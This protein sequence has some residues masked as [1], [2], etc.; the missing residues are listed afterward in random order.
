[1]LLNTK[2]KLMIVLLLFGLFHFSVTIADLDT[3]ANTG[4]NLSISDTV[5]TTTAFSG[6]V[7]RNNTN[8]RF[9]FSIIFN[10]ADSANFSVVNITIPSNFTFQPSGLDFNRSNGIGSV[11]V[12]GHA[13]A[14][15]G[16]GSWNFGNSTD[17][18]LSNIWW[19]NTDNGT[20]PGHYIFSV[21]LT[22]DKVD[23]IGHSRRQDWN[24]TIYMA[25]ST[26][27]T[28]STLMYTYIDTY[29]PQ[30]MSINISDGLVGGNF[31]RANGTGQASLL[32]QT[33]SYND[34]AYMPIENTTVKV[35]LQ[36]THFDTVDLYYVC[37]SS[38]ATAS[39]TETASTGQYGNVSMTTSDTQS[40]N[41]T[42][43]GV[44]DL[45]CVGT[46]SDGNDKGDT[47]GN[48]TT[49]VIRA[50]DTVGNSI[51]INDTSDNNFLTDNP[52]MFI[53]LDGQPNITALNI[54]DEAGNV[55]D[56]DKNQLGSGRSGVGYLQANSLLTFTI[57]GSGGVIAVAANT[58]NKNAYGYFTFN[59]TA[60]FGTEEN[61]GVAANGYLNLTNITTGAYG[62]T[63][64]TLYNGTIGKGVANDSSDG[65][66][67][68]FIIKINS[69]AV[70]QWPKY[71]R[72]SFVLDGGVPTVAL[73][74]PADKNI[75]PFSS[76]K[77]GCSGTDSVSGMNTCSIKITKP[78][79]STITKTSE[80][81]SDQ[82]FKNTDT[83]EAGTYNVECTTK[84]Q[85]GHT[86]TSTGI[87]TF[88]VFTSTGGGDAS[89][90]G[91]GS[92]ISRS[93]EELVLDADLST[94]DKTTFVGSQGS[95]KV[96]S[97]SGTDAHTITFVKVNENTLTFTIESYKAEV[98]LSVGETKD[99]DMDGDG[100]PNA[101]VTLES[102]TNGVA[103][104]TV[105][106]LKDLEVVAE[107]ESAPSEE[108]PT[109][110]GDIEEKISEKGFGRIMWIVTIIVIVL[111]IV[112]YFYVK[113]RD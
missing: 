60:D 10:S 52:F 28:N 11:G 40:G 76:I 57:E 19:N 31:S 25:D 66:Y 7:Q 54:T 45:D 71:Y 65:N 95:I 39:T 18:T 13:N 103:T 69:T 37:N 93:G 36:D 47:K 79:G 63:N 67:T 29:Y 34:G 55:L 82:E 26:S 84:D 22:A 73:T 98:T 1:M 99:V 27:A 89:S 77:Y 102:I 12:D 78:G 8:V 56:F 16:S 110:S 107:E 87:I 49:F 108:I 17:G 5:A 44:I 92:G 74:E 112:G 101:Q 106:K 24:V 53:G 61:N 68:N 62:A 38:N 109:V 42:Y 83:N 48:A 90:S 94:S 30:I 113:R 4:S 97:L 43:E 72:G 91:G 51:T 105:L 100:T 23:G 15:N 35:D 64:I 20:L 2:I 96:F 6:I 86:T 81:C 85:V 59:T 50:Y 14:T 75:N 33:G 104:I 88:S 9:N 32:F 80:T 46:G 70:A 58:R 21:N 3:T 41:R 111:I